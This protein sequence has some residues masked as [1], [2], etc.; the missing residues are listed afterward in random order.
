M[1]ALLFVN[2]LRKVDSWQLSVLEDVDKEVAQGDQV[3]SSA[4][5]VKFQLVNTCK[6]HVASEDVNLGLFNV[7]SGV[8][9][10]VTSCKPI[11]N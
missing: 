2:V 10:D 4:G 9:V 11:V 6:D 3:I 7:F 1:E 8:F 5:H